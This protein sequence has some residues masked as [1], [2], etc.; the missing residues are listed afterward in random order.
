MIDDYEL[1]DQQKAALATMPLMIAVD[2][3]PDGDV[4][5]LDREHPRP[6]QAI[7]YFGPY[8]LTREGAL[9]AVNWHYRTHHLVQV[10]I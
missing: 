2:T 4:L 5:V 3:L 9:H 7:R 6:H 1:T 8:I 10:P